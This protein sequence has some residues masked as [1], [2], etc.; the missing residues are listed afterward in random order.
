MELDN[1]GKVT[2]FGKCASKLTFQ[3]TSTVHRMIDLIPNP[4]RRVFRPRM[5][6]QFSWSQTR[7]EFHARA[8]S[9]VGEEVEL[10][11]SC[12]DISHHKSKK[13]PQFT[14]NCPIL[15]FCFEKIPLLPS[16]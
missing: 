12:A 11:P 8:I 14:T 10:C 4:T 16:F 1:F 7:L 5:G 13:L 3:K 6:S 15:H 2:N 9:K